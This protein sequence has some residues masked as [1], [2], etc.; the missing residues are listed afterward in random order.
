MSSEKKNGSIICRELLE[1]EG[2]CETPITS[3]RT[4]LYYERRPCLQLVRDAAE[5]IE[6]EMESHI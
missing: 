3:E 2:K 6:K 4:K 1:L 5:Q